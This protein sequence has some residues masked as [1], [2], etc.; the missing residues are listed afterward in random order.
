M[1]QFAA[2]V[3]AALNPLLA[4]LPGAVRLALER[5]ADETAAERVGSRTR[6][7]AALGRV[8]L[9][10]LRADPVDHPVALG[11]TSHVAARMQALLEPPTR[12][13]TAVVAA[14][15][16]SLALTAFA[17][18]G[19]GERMDDLAD[20]AGSTMSHARQHPQP[21]APGQINP[22]APGPDPGGGQ[23]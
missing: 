10:R 15:L 20:T 18:V 22:E 16:A 21:L 1:Y 11:A 5:W 7:A 23:L 4:S 17:T 13:R 12:T 6:V 19:A 2:A 14:I 8:A 9:L 3:A